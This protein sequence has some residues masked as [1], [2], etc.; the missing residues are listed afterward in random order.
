MTVTILPVF[1]L[2]GSK[3]TDGLIVYDA[4]TE[5]PSRSSATIVWLP[6][7]DAGIAKLALNLPFASATTG[8]GL[9]VRVA[10]S[11]VKRI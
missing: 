9:V 7:I 2:G 11:N 6:W 3:V 10:A 1:P 4:E 5:P 8:D